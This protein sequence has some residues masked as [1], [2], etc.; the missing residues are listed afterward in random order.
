MAVITG[1]QVM[2]AVTCV[3]PAADAV[4]NVIDVTVAGKPEKLT[5]AS[6]LR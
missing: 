5:R 6:D 1:A 4:A 3:K 2:D